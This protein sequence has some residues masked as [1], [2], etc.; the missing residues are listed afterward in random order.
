MRAT[1]TLRLAT[2][3]VQ[4]GR[5][6]Q[7]VL[8]LDGT[9]RVVADLDADV[10]GL[11]EV[12]VHSSRSRFRNQAAVLAKA[13]GMA[14]AYA[15]VA[16]WGAGGTFGNAVLVRGTIERREV[17]ALPTP[18]GLAPRTALLAS[19][20][21][22][23]VRLSVA[24]THLSVHGADARPQLAAVAEALAAEPAPRVLLGD[25]NLEWAQVDAALAGLELELAGGGPT[26][27][28][29]EPRARIDHIG[30]VG[31]AFEDV[32]V[33]RTTVSDHRPVYADVTVG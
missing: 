2:F 14:A 24:V 4:H 27:P 7:R 18:A 1:S 17:V 3:N 20:Q 31:L 22:A 8:D 12:D 15:P 5:N 29:D 28:A 30:A 16:R 9:R 33:V 13:A 6:A 23:S 11:Q 26:F 32:V 19:V 21:L 25:L 10:V